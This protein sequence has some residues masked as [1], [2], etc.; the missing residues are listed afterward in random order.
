MT[1]PTNIYPSSALPDLSIHDPINAKL[2]S[3][4]RDSCSVYY[5][6]YIR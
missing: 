5:S 4:L 2:K 6:R 3:T 1:K